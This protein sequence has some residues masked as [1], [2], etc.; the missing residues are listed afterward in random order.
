MKLK[1]LVLA[2]VS[3]LSLQAQTAKKK[4][5]GKPKSVAAT[6]TV[7]KADDGIFA[8]IDTPKGTITLQLL[9][10][11]TP[12]TVA[13]FISLAE[14]TN[15]AVSDA[16]KGKHFY[17]GLK[18]H[19][20]IA[21]FMIQGGDP[22]GNGSGGPGYAFKDET[23]PDDKF[24]RAGIL[25]MANAGPAT[26][27]SQFFITHKDT[28]WLNGK[29]T[30]FGYVT[31][32]QDVVN[33]IQQDD[34]I[35]KV[36]IVRKGADAK[37]FDAAK[38]FSDYFAGKAEDDKK[39]EAIKAEARKQQEA[40]AAEKKKEYL[41]K[42]G[43]VV[44]KK[45]VELAGLKSGAATTPSGLAYK[46]I[47]KGKGAKPADGAQV[48]INYAGYLED[49]TL[50]DTSMPDVAKAFGTYD[51]NRD[52]QGG[53]KPFP[54]N[55]GNKQGLIAGFTEALGLMNIGD[56][57]LAFIPANLGYGE[58]GAG[59]V[60]PPNSNIIFEIELLDKQP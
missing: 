44:K 22:N 42:Y 57:I 28:P 15:T 32:G 21:D 53:Y 12:V 7:A 38:V 31:A 9:Y 13:N 6:K 5:A 34:P 17:D 19:R 4:A 41:A 36:T 49:G 2:F 35:N 45:S 47:T 18:F 24:D 50:F 10:K 1:F 59:N 51:E 23:T 48:F 54:F 55:Y 58:R 8:N 43:D 26:N 60:I 27:G 3:V 29:H 40:M 46:F 20:V 33:K 16:Y 30:I 37:A 25:A 11:K 14:G 52:K 56:K 39:M